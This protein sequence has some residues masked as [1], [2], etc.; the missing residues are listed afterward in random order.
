MPISATPCEEEDNVVPDEEGKARDFSLSNDLDSDCKKG[1]IPLLIEN[2]FNETGLELRNTANFGC[3][4]VL[5][6]GHT[7]TKTLVSCEVQKLRGTT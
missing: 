6:E 1:S 3:F 7:T 2:R 5:V 4:F